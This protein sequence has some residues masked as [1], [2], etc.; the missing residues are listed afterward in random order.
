MWLQE[1]NPSATIQLL[2]TDIHELTPIGD[3][4]DHTVVPFQIHSIPAPATTVYMGKLH[5]ALLCMSL[6][7]TG[8]L[9]PPP[10]AK[11][12]LST[13]FLPQSSKNGHIQL[14]PSQVRVI[15]KLDVL[16]IEQTQ[17]HCN[18]RLAEYG[19]IKQPGKKGL[20]VIC[21]L[22]LHMNWSCLKPSLLPQV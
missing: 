14:N 8:K 6:C 11:D 12:F 18:K 19:H 13:P 15:I 9:N 21:F 7:R 17:E 16:S 10:S 1:G 5:Q 3:Q 20:W 22:E 2:V 4:K